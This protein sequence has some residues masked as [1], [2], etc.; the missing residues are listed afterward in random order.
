MS[1]IGLVASNGF[2]ASKCLYPKAASIDRAASK[3][4]DRGRLGHLKA[5]I[6]RGAPKEVKIL[7]G[8]YYSSLAR[9]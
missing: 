4:L 1:S 7:D 6:V 2:A 8:I 3:Y 5:S 9:S